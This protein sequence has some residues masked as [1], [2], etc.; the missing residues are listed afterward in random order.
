M[1]ETASP[2]DTTVNIDN[3]NNPSW[4]NNFQWP[5][6]LVLIL[7]AILKSHQLSTSPYTANLVFESRLF[8]AGLIVF[9]LVLAF[10][11][12]SRFRPK[13]ARLIALTTFIAF[14]LFGAEKVI[15]GAESCGC[16]GVF[17]IPPLITLTIDI[18]MIILLIMWPTSHSTKRL[19]IG[20][21]ATGLL[22][23]TACLFPVLTFTT[24]SLSDIGDVVGDGELVVVD[25]ATWINKR[26]PIV[27]FIDGDSNYMEADWKMILYHEDCPIC[28]S[29][30]QKTIT[31][32]ATPTVFVEVPPY[33]SPARTDSQ[34]LLWRK[35]LDDHEWFVAAPDAIELSDGIV[36]R[37]LGQLK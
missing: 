3:Q 19:S 9:E 35:M 12:L 20:W 11:L 8:T 24:S 28:Q 33:K 30:I 14:C 7:A 27:K 13:I 16:F 17:E 5:P 32:R 23:L 31:E 29:I 15:S 1:N 36:V 26:L 37:S 6:A 25:T 2:K 22:T 18:G 21:L 10:W 4:R 34:G